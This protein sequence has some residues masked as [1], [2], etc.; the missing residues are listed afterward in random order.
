MGGLSGCRPGRQ[1][2]DLPLAT[3]ACG[4]FLFPKEGCLLSEQRSAQELGVSVG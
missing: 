3:S 1:G 4:G 2:L